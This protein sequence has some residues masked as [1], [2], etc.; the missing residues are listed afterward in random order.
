MTSKKYLKPLKGTR[1]RERKLIR[2]QSLRRSQIRVKSSEGVNQLP[3][4]ISQGKPYNIVAC[5]RLF[6]IFKLRNNIRLPNIED[7][8]P[9]RLR[10]DERWH[11]NICY[12]PAGRSVW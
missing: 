8:S 3:L 9:D 12:L 7:V 1:N 11:G 5:L 10:I 6:F 4:I 2:P